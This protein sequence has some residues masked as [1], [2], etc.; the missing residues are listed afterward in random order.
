[1]SEKQLL[2]GDKAPTFEL[3]N[4]ANETITNSTNTSANMVLFFY[5]KD[6]T[7]GCTKEACSFSELKSQF[8][9]LNTVIYGISKDSIASHQKFVTKNQ[10]QL[11]LL[12]DNTGE[13]CEKFG[14]YREKSMYGK[15][16]LGIVRS[17]FFI[18]STGTIKMI[19]DNVKVK[20]H[21]EDVYEWVKSNHV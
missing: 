10:L 16:Y 20:G 5:P 13:I 1:M 4:Q 19:W 15:T 6:M 17:T 18:D 3:K 21:V 9:E 7:P 11:S 14:V 8:D 2:I 12:S